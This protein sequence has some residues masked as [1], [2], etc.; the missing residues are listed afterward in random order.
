MKSINITT[1]LLAL[2]AML[3]V[4]CDSNKGKVEEQA[5]LFVAAV[6]NKD[7][8]TIYDIYPEA[9]NIKNMSLPD[10]IVIG[11]I[12]VEKTDSSL[13]IASIANTRMQ[14]LVFEV[15]G[16]N[17]IVLKDT[18]SVLELDSAAMELAIQTG[19]P[20][21][22]ISDLNISKLLDDGGDYL[23]HLKMVYSDQIKGG[24]VCEDGTYTWNRGY[25]AV[26]GSVTVHQSIRNAGDVPL[27]GSE[28]N[29]EFNF[30]CPN[31]TAAARKMV[32]SGVDLEPN[33]ATTLTVYPGSGYVRACN[34]KDFSWNVS[35][36]YKNLSPITT[37][38]KYVKF[39]GKEYDEYIALK[40]D[41]VIKEGSSDKGDTNIEAD[42][43]NTEVSKKI[44]EFYI[45]YV[46]GGE[47]VTEKVINKYCTKKLS[48]KLA[49]DYEYD[50]GGYAIWDFRTE[51]QDGDSEKSG[52]T[53]IESIGDYKYKVSFNDMGTNAACII[54]VVNEGGSILFDE[55]ERISE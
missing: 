34:N 47:E 42:S 30:Y 43:L 21:K 53:K 20:V 39:T 13:Y 46:F 28:Y 38:L 51:N 9:K 12:S 37:L 41:N 26:P 23:T 29:I 11:E 31:G 40:T 25:G 15:K 1:T 4:S 2:I 35:V 54:S 55:L 33:E 5:R 7:K 44:K 18:Y 52:V 17:A 6:N 3:F 19:V 50:D 22:E 49:D 16:E 45:K 32:E 48:K 8:A 24:L 36:T 27:K 14:K 10:S